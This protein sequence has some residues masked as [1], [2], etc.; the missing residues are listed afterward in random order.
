MNHE[1]CQ[2]SLHG[3]CNGEDDGPLQKTPLF[4][5]HTQHHKHWTLQLLQPKESVPPFSYTT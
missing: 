1:S 3:I 2:Q 4:I 5:Q